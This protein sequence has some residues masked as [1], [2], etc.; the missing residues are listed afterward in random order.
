MIASESAAY[1][2]DLRL[3]ASP[4]NL[5][6]DA[7]AAVKE[8]YRATTRRKQLRCLE[9]T[10]IDLSE[11]NDIYRLDVGQF[12]EFDWTWEGS[13]AFKSARDGDDGAVD[14]DNGTCVW[15][16]EVVEVDET[17]GHIYVYVPDPER[18][19]VT[20]PFTVRPF[21]FLAS[22]Q[23]V[24]NSPELAGLRTQLA[25]SLH[26]CRGGIHPRATC[27]TG[28][29]LAHLA[30]LW[31]HSWAILWGPPGTGKTYTV[32]DQLA[33]CCADEERFLI[34][35]TTNKATDGAALSLGRAFKKRGKDL[36]GQVIR[37]GKGAT[38]QD[39][40]ARGMTKLLDGSETDM[41]R[42][43]GELAE[44]L[45][46]T[47]DPEKRAVLRNTIQQRKRSM[48]ESSLRAFLN[49][50][51]RAVVT[52]AF[53]AL[54]TVTKPEIVE[55][56]EQG[57]APFTTVLIDEAGLIS[58]AT[59]AAL[60]V[61][62]SRRVVLVGDP[63][64]LAPIARMSRILPRKQALWLGASALDHLD[65]KRS[66]GPGVH[67]LQIQYRMH[68]QIRAVVS[69]YQY[70]DLLQD[71]PGVTSRSSV[72]PGIL[73]DQARAIWY[74]LDEE[75]DGPAIRAERGSG[76][77][78]WVRPITRK[79]LNKLFSEPAL[80]AC[81]GLIL[82]PFTAQARDLSR[83]LVEEGMQGW[84]AST[85]HSQQGAEA[86]VVIFDT[87]NAGSHCWPNGEWQRLINVG[88]SRARASVILLA[89]RAELRQP[90]LSPLHD[91]LAPRILCRHGK[92]LTWKEVP[93][94]AAHAAAEKVGGDPSLLGNQLRKRKALRPVMSCEQQRLCGFNMDGKPRVVR[95]V[96]GSGK[97]HILAHWLVKTVRKLA[98]TPDARIWA[99][100]ANDALRG[101]IESCIMEAWQTSEDGPFPW[102]RV[103]LLQV[104]TLLR[105]LFQQAGLSYNHEFEY[106]A[107]A[108]QYLATV[109]PAQIVA[110]CDALFVD[111]AQDA[112]PN[113]L[114]LL[115]A[116]VRQTQVD[117]PNSRA[118]M[119][120][121][122]NA[123]NI[124]RRA[125]PIW[126]EFGLGMTGRSVVMKESFR[127]TKPI[128]EFA[129]N[130]LYKLKPAEVKHKEHK[131]LLVDHGLIEYTQRQGKPW[132]DVRFNQID[133]PLPSFHQFPRLED[134]FDAIG[135]QLVHW[136]EKEK[137][138]PRDIRILYIGQNIRTVHLPRI[139]D[140]VLQKI[141][142]RL[143]LQAGTALDQNADA[144]IATPPHSF[145]GYDSEILV[146]AGL[147][148]F[149]ATDKSSGKYQILANELYVAMTRARSVLAI[150]TQTR[151][152]DTEGGKINRVVEECLDIM[153]DSAHREIAISRMDDFSNLLDR[154]G[155]DHQAWLENLW[156]KHTIVQERL[157]APSGE[158]LAEPLFWFKADERTTA[159][160]SKGTPSQRVRNRL[161]D[162]A[163]RIIQPG[164][165]W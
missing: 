127:S 145:K 95:G 52:T 38:F 112:G 39:F 157:V 136:I 117:E 15:S 49:R 56:V 12:V 83:F 155:A 81:Q 86:D 5:L 60:S 34:V 138:A 2:R 90:Y 104:R 54:L 153:V 131:E 130:V 163:V 11:G 51:H 149:V 64:Q 62:A 108:Q 87:V 116:L 119:I 9:A 144:V 114:R 82:A 137:V 3:P 63:R 89:S 26:A 85:V 125:T 151:P 97:T 29:G 132:W 46:G 143:E 122:D 50:H 106:D 110:Q 18:P 84:S 103:S 37:V 40:Q 61:L 134:E 91:L 102:N 69:R 22:L 10:P 101:L 6:P 23:Q 43:I 129:L 79:I 35:S 161:E 4:G 25:P 126:A 19:P 107:A 133:G 94:G 124:Y 16:G 80:R 76:N 57:Q 128:A 28:A 164:E 98:G 20:G 36:D 17:R 96:A 78:S 59:V 14:E 42:R 65:P 73:N 13:Q 55:L 139:R 88:L 21:E 140:E 67:M 99:V 152:A 41:R 58:R 30:E 31:R 150:Y 135:H 32:G 93:S 115:T 66:A 123:Q 77:R 47:R 146:I 111:E 1:L 109:P 141:G 147:N 44:A 118:V 113:T 148:Q 45:R 162:E 75:E 24:Y 68:P 156:K 92:L 70:H 27:S 8:E 154:V 105:D 159:C 142:V 120:F 160:F 7:A 33:E 72:L 53:N 74:V 71:A 165:V 48:K 121:Y 100:Y 158:L